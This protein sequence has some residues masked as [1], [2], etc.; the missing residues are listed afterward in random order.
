MAHLLVDR[1]GD[2]T[3]L[4]VDDRNV[5]VRRSHGSR[6]CLVSIGHR[7]HGVRR[8]I[9]KDGRELDEPESC[10]LRRGDE[11]FALQ[12]HVDAR[13]RHEPV[14]LDRL[15]RVAVPLQQ[16]RSGDD[17]LQLE[18]RMGVDRLE[19]R[20]DPRVAGTRRNND[21]DFSLA[22]LGVN[23]GDGGNGF[24][25]EERSN[26]GERRR[27]GHKGHEGHQAVRR[28]AE[29]GTREA[30]EP[31]TSHTR[32]RS[33]LFLGSLASRVAAC[34]AGRALNGLRSSPLLRCSVLNRWL[35]NLRYLPAPRSSSRII[36]SAAIA[37]RSVR[38]RISPRRAAG[39]PVPGFLNARCASPMTV[40]AASGWR[41][42]ML[43]V[44][45]AR[46]GAVSAAAASLSTGLAIICS[47]KRTPST[48][49]R[50]SSIVTDAGT[51]GP[52]MPRLI[53]TCT[54]S[55][56][57]PSVAAATPGKIVPE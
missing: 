50:S 18:S 57:L 56:S 51:S 31:K 11:V 21:A 7:D 48:S 14:V 17:E 39:M 9:V 6:E 46:S 30:R 26:G 24:Y 29:G 15:N 3:P 33:G 55:R 35:R 49:C 25:T 28:A 43:L 34:C 5:H 20:A 52:N 22:H 1:A 54:S 12:H 44:K 23:G 16:R 4:H 13:G 42:T 38:P 8:Q 27:F 45:M 47:T 32:N 19:R 53:V 41:A 40:P 10:R 2:L 37:R 36:S